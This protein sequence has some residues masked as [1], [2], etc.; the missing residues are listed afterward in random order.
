MSCLRS[1][2]ISEARRLAHLLNNKNIWDKLRDYIPFPYGCDDGIEFINMVKQESPQQTFGIHYQDQ[3]C[4]V[5]CVIIQ[6]DVYRKSGELGYWLGEEYWGRGIATRAV[7]EI[8]DYGFNTLNL[9]R[10]FA[11]VFENNVG[12]CRVLEKNDFD[13]EAVFKNAIYKNN[14]LYHEFRYAKL[15]P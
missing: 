4:G 1:L 9:E 6:K 7:S 13:Q 15:R 2:Q 5:I 10:I 11:G 12:S 3:L 8:V 14:S